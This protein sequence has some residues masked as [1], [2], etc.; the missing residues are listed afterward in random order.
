MY[1]TYEPFDDVVRDDW[2]I[3]SVSWAYRN[4]IVTGYEDNLFGPAD[5]VTREQMAVILHRYAKYKE[6]ETAEAADLAEFPD[7]ADVSDFA[8]EAMSWCVS[9]G[10]ICGNDGKL[11]PQDN[12]TR[13]ECAAM[14]SRFSEKFD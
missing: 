1:S 14:I 13:A 6:Y 9:E 11:L 12:V 5:P 3:T 7:A 4:E 10:I 8:K 2:F